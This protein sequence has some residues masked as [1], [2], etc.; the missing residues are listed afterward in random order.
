MCFI[1]GSQ[2]FS[3]GYLGITPQAFRIVNGNDRNM[4]PENTSFVKNRPD[5][6]LFRTAIELDEVFQQFRLHPGGAISFFRTH[7]GDIKIKV[8]RAFYG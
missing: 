3:L 7:I 5:V 4:S 6:H 8:Y 2:A 1:S